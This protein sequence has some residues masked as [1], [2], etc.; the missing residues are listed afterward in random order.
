MVH[1][2]KSAYLSKFYKIAQIHA[3]RPVFLG[4]F[5][6]VKFIVRFLESACFTHNLTAVKIGGTKKY[7]TCF[8]FDKITTFNRDLGSDTA[9]ND[10]W[11][12]RFRSDALNPFLML[13]IKQDIVVVLERRAKV[14]K[15]FM[16]VAPGILRPTIT[17]RT[18]AAPT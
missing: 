16:I 17:S 12:N 5:G 9:S 1:G 15:R 14:L 10:S 11:D 8:L 4:I 7:S 2:F 3:M 6:K 13:A 18:L